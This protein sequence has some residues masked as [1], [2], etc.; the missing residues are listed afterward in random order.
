MS[1]VFLEYIWL[2]GNNPQ[3]LRSKTKV[4]ED[5]ETLESKGNPKQGYPESYPLWSFDGSSTKQA[6][7]KEYEFQGT[8]CVLKPVYVVEDPFR[9]K[10]HKLV[11]CEVFNPDGVTP[12]KTNTRFKLRELLSD[13][14]FKE[15]DA[16]HSEVPW[17]GWEQE[18]VITHAVNPLNKFK[19]GGGIPLGF[20]TTQDGNPRPQGDYYCGVGGLNVVGREIV[21]EHLQKCA[22]IGLSIGG[23]NAEVLIGQW[24][25][26]I[27]PV[28][29]LNGS[30]Q[31]WVSRYI[32][33][34]VAEKRGYGISYHPK[35]VNGDWNGSG[36]HV[37]FSTKEMREK[38]GLKK[39]LEACKKLKERHLEHIEGYGEFN[40]KR[41]TGKHET[42]SMDSFSFGNSNRSSSIRIPVHTYT[43]EKGY[44][45]DRRPAANCDPYKVSNL[46]IETVFD[47]VSIT[48]E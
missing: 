7:T 17:F 6:A 33:E 3:N 19:Y 4:V 35:P 18:Y 23:I 21:E 2:D 39:I 5:I 10:K 15:F 11:F 38:G 16:N 43:N 37:N 1:K 34:R 30:D 25:Y 26:Q 42:S 20:Q 46:M 12:H 22:E 47:K 44:F 31:L 41:L 48:I 32:L 27:G 36:C 24:E 13:L 29:A 28:T 45:E 9:G 8:D 40:D 14:K